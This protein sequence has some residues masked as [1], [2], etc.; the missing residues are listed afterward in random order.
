MKYA[1]TPA[2]TLERAAERLRDLAVESGASPDTEVLRL[3]GGDRT[4]LFGLP[5]TSDEIRAGRFPPP[6]P[7]KEDRERRTTRTVG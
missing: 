5:G 3:R 2:G 7:A 1:P 6:P 4:I